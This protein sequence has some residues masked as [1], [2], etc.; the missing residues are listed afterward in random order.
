LPHSISCTGPSS[1]PSGDPAPAGPVGAVVQ[2]ISAIEAVSRTSDETRRKILAALVIIESPFSGARWGTFFIGSSAH[3]AALN[4][5]NNA[6]RLALGL[7]DTDESRMKLL[8][9]HLESMQSFLTAS[10]TQDQP[11]L[12]KFVNALTTIDPSDSTSFA[13]TYILDDELHTHPKFTP[14]KLAPLSYRTRRI[15]LLSVPLL[16]VGAGV[17]AVIALWVVPLCVCVCGKRR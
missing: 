16:I 9:V 14:F 12:A 4:R 15:Q 7:L 6:L 8:R 11:L 1:S 5:V 13:S 2:A 10:T 17:A 3:Q